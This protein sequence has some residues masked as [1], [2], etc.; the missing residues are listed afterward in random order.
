VV[1]SM[2]GSRGV[3]F[4]WAYV[5]NVRTIHVCLSGTSFL[6]SRKYSPGQIFHSHFGK[7]Q[8]R[9]R[10]S[11]ILKDAHVLIFGACEYAVMWW[12]DFEDG[13]PLEIQRWGNYHLSGSWYTHSVLT[14]GQET[15]LHSEGRRGGLWTEANVALL[16][17]KTEQGAVNSEEFGA[18]D[19]LLYPP[20]G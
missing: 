12:K 15:E 3:H 8:G 1:Y 2:P 10:W 17:W 5:K 19:C 6:L 18:T 7:V 11:M 16:V 4:I 13:V 9:V 14:R 20:E